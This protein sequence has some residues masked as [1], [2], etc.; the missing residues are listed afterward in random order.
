MSVLILFKHMPLTSS[1]R[2]PFEYLNHIRRFALDFSSAYRPSCETDRFE[3][4]PRH[5]CRTWKISTALACYFSRLASI[6]QRIQRHNH[7]GHEVIARDGLSGPGSRSI[8]ERRVAH[9]PLCRRP[10]AGR[11]CA[12]RRRDR[13]RVPC[14]VPPRHRLIRLRLRHHW[15]GRHGGTLDDRVRHL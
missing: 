2:A 1:C 12:L 10:V 4:H 14:P 7:H 13:H 8:Y 9:R 11:L 5:L 15:R 6:P 3:A